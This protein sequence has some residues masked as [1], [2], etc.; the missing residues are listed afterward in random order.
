M[1]RTIMANHRIDTDGDGIADESPTFTIEEGE[2]Y[3][4]T[5]TFT[6][7]NKFTYWENVGGTDGVFE[8]GLDCGLHPFL[9]N[10]MM[11]IEEAEATT[12]T[13]DET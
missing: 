11:T 12:D 1:L 4:L 9:P 3:T 6:F 5:L 13:T 7:D 10:I 8:L 2:A